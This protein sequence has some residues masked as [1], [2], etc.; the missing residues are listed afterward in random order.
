MRAREHVRTVSNS[1]LTPVHTAGEG[2]CLLGAG[3][4][5][6]TRRSGVPGIG[7]Y[8]SGHANR[9]AGTAAPGFRPQP[10]WDFEH[11]RVA[12]GPGEQYRD[13]GHTSPGFRTHAYR[14]WEHKGTGISDTTIDPLTGIANI[15]STPNSLHPFGNSPSNSV[16]LNS[17][18]NSPTGGVALFGGGEGK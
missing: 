7:A 3:Q 9:V 16:L 14:E 12:A 4:Q 5:R 2:T 6:H 10:Y 8:P 13:S 1:N 11:S 17:D 18:Q 15:S